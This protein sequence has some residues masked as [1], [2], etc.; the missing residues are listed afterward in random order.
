M[1]VIK[2]II[3]IIFLI[4]IAAFAVVNRH[5]VEVFYYD[6]QMAKQMIEAPLI[7]VG[8]IP[9]MLGFLLAWT[10]TIVSQV[11]SKAAIGKRNRAIKSLEKD[12]QRLTPDGKT[13]ASPVGVHGK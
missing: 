7:I 13:S 3:A 11:K 2:F 8:L 4:A 9:F 10:F 12:V 5:S 1:S 6:L